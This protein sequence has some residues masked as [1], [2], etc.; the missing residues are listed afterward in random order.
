MSEAPATVVGRTAENI[1][2]ELVCVIHMKR[3][4]GWRLMSKKLI[5]PLDN[6]SDRAYII[7]MRTQ[8]EKK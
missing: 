2:L 1:P 7:Y 6:P 8:K 5:K 4:N 3:L